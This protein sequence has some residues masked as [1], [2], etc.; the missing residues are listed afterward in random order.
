[1]S[2]KA[3]PALRQTGSVGGVKV[4]DDGGKCGR[5][6]AT[7]T[8]HRQNENYLQ[9]SQSLEVI[10]CLFEAVPISRWLVRSDRLLSL[11]RRARPAS[12]R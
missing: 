4:D 9:T 7:Q 6:A 8:Q 1:L 10:A 3:W 2:S 5:C 12:R 11:R